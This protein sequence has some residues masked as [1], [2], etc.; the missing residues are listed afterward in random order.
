MII[1]KLISS[2]S[3][4][5]PLIVR[6]ECDSSIVQGAHMLAKYQ[7]SIEE[8]CINFTIGTAQDVKYNSKIHGRVLETHVVE[9]YV[10]AYGDKRV[11]RQFIPIFK[12]VGTSQRSNSLN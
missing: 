9:T 8:R 1:C 10:D 3:T 2:V 11:R 5:Q 4:N 7:A 12:M 6:L